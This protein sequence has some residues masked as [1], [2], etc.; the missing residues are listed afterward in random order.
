M[1]CLMANRLCFAMSI[2]TQIKN[3]AY[4]LICL[5]SCCETLIIAGTATFGAKL[6]QL[7]FHVD[8]MK[9]GFV[10]GRFSIK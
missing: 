4:V 7:F 5:A 3:P 10:M 6:L 2:L 1:H 9:A 8:L